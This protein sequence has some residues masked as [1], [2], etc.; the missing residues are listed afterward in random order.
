MKIRDKITLISSLLTGA[1]LL[2]IFLFIYYFSYVYTENEFY[3]KLRER[4]GVVARANLDRDEMDQANYEKLLVEHLQTLPEEQEII[5]PVDTA[6]KKVLTDTRLPRAFLDGVFRDGYEQDKSGSTYRMGILYHDNEGDFIIV[7]S[8]R[9]ISGAGQ[10]RRL[11]NILILSF[12]LGLV[13]TYFGGIL[14]AGRVLSPISSITAKANEISATNLYLRLN[15]SNKGD[16]LDELAI[17]F[18]HMLD[19]LETSF[20]TQNSFIN[21][22]SHELR[23]PLTAILGETEISLNRERSGPEYRQSLETIQ[24]E[25]QR[26]DLLVNSLLKLAQTGMED[27]R[28]IITPLRIDELLLDVKQHLDGIRPDNRIKFDL[29]ELP[30]ES[31]NLMIQGNESLL[32]VAFNNYL[33]NACKFS[34]NQEVTVKIL[35]NK[36]QVSIIISDRGVGIPET[37]IPKISEPFFRADNARAFRGFG[38]GLPLASKIIKI[39]GGHTSIQSEV[40]KGTRVLVHF[41][42]YR[43]HKRPP[44]DS[45]SI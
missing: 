29:S 33:D 44:L 34:D 43:I 21:N 19:R 42:N 38:V 26:L 31:D 3:T 28:F 24:N 39:H 11:L 14:Y 4:N 35:G 5:L 7:L 20:E 27:K 25:A 40:G 30:R 15:T 23:N 13:L 12:L 10:M 6:N 8:A 41:P 45:T 18:N 16:E 36:K 17:T 22:A 1:L 9:D 32:T 2:F 37:D